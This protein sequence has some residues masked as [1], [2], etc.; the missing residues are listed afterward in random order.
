MLALYGHPEPGGWWERHLEKHLFA[1]GWKS[2][3]DWRSTYW[4]QGLK[5]MLSVYVDDFKLSGPEKNVPIGWK[6]IRDGVNMEGPTPTGKY[7]GCNHTLIECH[8][9]PGGDPINNK[10]PAGKTRAI[11]VRAIEYDMCDFMKSC[12]D[13]YLECADGKARTL[14][15][16]ETPFI[17][18]S[19]DPGFWESEEAT[20]KSLGDKAAS[21]L[22][23]VLYAARMAR[24]DLYE[25]PVRL[26]VN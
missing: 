8:M 22:M 21:I 10:V 26:L 12:V 16:V 23:K 25:R 20:G 19:T 14:P 13:R 6:S 18:E 1:T 4:H 15:K 7:L 2:I 3:A 17:E 9:T 5:L 24:L 11:P